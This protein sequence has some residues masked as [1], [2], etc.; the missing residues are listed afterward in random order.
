MA[1]KKKRQ[2]TVSDKPGVKK[3]NRQEGNSPNWVWLFSGIFVGLFIAVIGILVW[4][5]SETHS[6]ELASVK[7]TPK[8]KPTVKEAKE[9][10]GT[11]FEFFEI[12]PELEVLVPNSITADKLELKPGERYMLQ[13]G[14]FKNRKDAE[15]RKLELAFLGI[16]STIQ[17]VTIDEKQTWHRV[18]AGPFDSATELNRVQDILKKKGI[19]T[20][21]VKVKG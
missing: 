6:V 2:A 10:K 4:K 9:T 8:A 20:L 19:K 7:E 17:T 5:K 14:S 12:L 1:V 11:E 3:R 18:K 16:E 13:T 21:R 15:S